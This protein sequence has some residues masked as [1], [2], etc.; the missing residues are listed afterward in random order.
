V[1]LIVKYGKIIYKR[2]IDHTFSGLFRIK[3]SIVGP[4]VLV[5]DASILRSLEALFR[6]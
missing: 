1:V 2:G 5:S 4:I 3:P 6:G